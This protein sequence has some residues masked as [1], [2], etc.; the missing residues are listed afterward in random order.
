MH[1]KKDEEETTGH[2]TN[3]KGWSWRSD[4]FS[5]CEPT[6]M[7]MMALEV[8]GYGG[9]PRLIEAQRL[10]LDRQIPGGGWNYGNT[11]VFGQVLNPMPESTPV[12][13]ENSKG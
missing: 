10:L 1:W 13:A 5:W 8:A 4:T 11:T 7:A 3:L 9:H 6:S 2:D 12:M